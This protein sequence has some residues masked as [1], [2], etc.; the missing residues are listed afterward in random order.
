M[1]TCKQWGWEVLHFGNIALDGGEKYCTQEMAESGRRESTAQLIR[2]TAEKKEAVPECGDLA[3]GAPQPPA[4][5]QTV[6]RMG[7]VLHDA[8]GPPPAS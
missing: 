8:D 5:E 4:S 2:P 6:S 7:G 3:L 1:Y